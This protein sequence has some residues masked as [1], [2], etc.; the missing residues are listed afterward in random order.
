M[1]CVGAAENGRPCNRRIDQCCDAVQRR[2]LHHRAKARD[3]MGSIQS[4]QRPVPA[5]AGGLSTGWAA[6]AAALACLATPSHVAICDWRRLGWDIEPPTSQAPVSFN[7]DQLRHLATCIPD[8]SKPE[9][10]YSSIASKISVLADCGTP[11][12]LKQSKNHEA[13]NNRERRPGKCKGERRQLEI[14]ASSC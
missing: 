7:V 1:M 14:W 10:C 6:T 11:G 2:D 4:R 12:T 5:S 13:P 9:Q 8:S 3:S